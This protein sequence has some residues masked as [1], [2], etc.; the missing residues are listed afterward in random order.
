MHY[1]SLKCGGPEGVWVVVGDGV[2]PSDAD[3]F[4][5]QVVKSTMT[6]TIPPGGLSGP[7]SGTF[8]TRWTVTTYDHL[9]NISIDN[10]GTDHTY[11]GTAAF[12]PEGVVKTD[13]AQTGS[14]FDSSGV[15]P[16][17]PSPDIHGVLIPESGT[18][19]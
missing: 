16:F 9:G 10:E 8:T 13:Y 6:F 5:P 4:S 19:C 1:Q 17:P 3:G 7:L 11:S 14:Y 18:F 2:W 15:H 12:L